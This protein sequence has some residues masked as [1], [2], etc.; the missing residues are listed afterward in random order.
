MAEMTLIETF[1]CNEVAHEPIEIAQEAVS[2]IDELGLTGQRD[3]IAK[4]GD[5]MTTRAPYRV[6][7]QDEIGVY[8]TLCPDEVEIKRYNGSPIP[9]RVL[10]VAAHAMQ[11]IP[12]LTI[13]VW[14]KTQA[15][16]KDPVLVGKVGDR[17]SANYKVYILARWGAELEAF[18]IL[19][20]KAVAMIRDR[21]R[22][23][24]KTLLATL[25]NATVDNLLAL[26]RSSVPS[27]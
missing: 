16:V 11:V 3:F 17:W 24:A 18:S 22:D 8:S 19:R 12:G 10:Q 20:N 26:R 1:E 9:L 7:T 15:V 25:D 2:I 21:L 6:M 14:D 4:P 23:E 27:V 13:E 5:K